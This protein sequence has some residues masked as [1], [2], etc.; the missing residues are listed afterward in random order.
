PGLDAAQQALDYGVKFSGCTVHFVDETL[1]GGPIILQAVVPV[2]PG[3]DAETLAS[4]ILIEEHK[5]YPEAIRLVATGAVRL[6]GR[7]VVGRRDG[8]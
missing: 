1:D 7:R 8:K 5:A 3:D 6:E 4:R 2:L